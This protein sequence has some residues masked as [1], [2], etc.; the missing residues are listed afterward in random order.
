MYVYLQL[1]QILWKGTGLMRI[2]VKGAYL[3]Y[4]I[5]Q[6][7]LSKNMWFKMVLKKEGDNRA[8]GGRSKEE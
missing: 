6:G 1:F 4:W 5:Q 8:V 7:G 3:F 2:Y